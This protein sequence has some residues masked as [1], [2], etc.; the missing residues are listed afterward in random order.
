MSALSVLLYVLGCVWVISS[1]LLAWRYHDAREA[2]DVT[3]RANKRLANENI[4]LYQAN[5]ELHMRLINSQFDLTKQKAATPMRYNDFG[6]PYY[7]PTPAQFSRDQIVAE[8]LVKET[9]ALERAKGALWRL[10]AAMV[11][12]ISAKGDGTGPIFSADK[13]KVATKALGL[14]MEN[15]DSDDVHTVAQWLKDHPGRIEELVG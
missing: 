14:A 10:N 6:K 5:N 2:L 4:N 13:E 7:P 8:L 1:A 3:R 12:G 9:D 11:K 15:L